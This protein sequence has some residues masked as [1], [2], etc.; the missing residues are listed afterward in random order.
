MPASVREGALAQADAAK[1]DVLVV[2]ENIGGRRMTDASSAILRPKW[3]PRNAVAVFQAVISFVIAVLLLILVAQTSTLASGM[4]TTMTHFNRIAAQMNETHVAEMIQ[5]TN[6]VMAHANRLAAHINASD[7]EAANNVISSI[8]SGLQTV[9]SL[10]PMSL[11]HMSYSQLAASL[12]GLDAKKYAIMANARLSSMITAMQTVDF[13]AT[14]GNC[15]APPSPPPAPYYPGDASQG[16]R[17]GEYD[18]TAYLY[19]RFNGRCLA[20]NYANFTTVLAAMQAVAGTV[21]GQFW[22][23]PASAPP[24]PSAFEAVLHFIELQANQTDTRQLGEL[25]STWYSRLVAFPW[26]SMTYNSYQPSSMYTS[27][28]LGT[29]Q[30][31]L[32]LGGT[33]AIEAMDHVTYFLENMNVV[34]ATL[35]A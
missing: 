26:T 20:Q 19:G 27:I 5:N 9:G 16:Y 8:Y 29:G 10:N 28:V 30:Q 35:N 13:T 34:C 31:T 6:D 1:V 24:M 15:I 22:E 17:Y 7:I 11:E 33:N 32:V 25:C 2:D 4:H 14:A 3:D 21:A 12:L 18:D 23:P